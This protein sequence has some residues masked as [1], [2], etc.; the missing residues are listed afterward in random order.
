M[1]INGG[2]TIQVYR[3]KGDP[4]RVRTEP[5][6]A[7]NPKEVAACCS[8]LWAIQKDHCDALPM[9]W[10]TCLLGIHPVYKD[11]CK[12]G[13]VYSKEEGFRL[14]TTLRSGCLKDAK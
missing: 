5:R 12:K 9:L 10:L 6:R 1:R 3:T 11:D 14:T 2:S 8:F 4:D 7:R 13:R